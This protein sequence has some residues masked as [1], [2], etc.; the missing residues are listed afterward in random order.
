MGSYPSAQARAPS[1]EGD[2]AQ[3]KAP[4]TSP[5]RPTDAV[6]CGGAPERDV[7][8]LDLKELRHDE[9]AA[10]L[11]LQPFGE[12]VD[13]DALCAAARRPGGDPASLD[14]RR[15]APPQRRSTLLREARADA[16]NLSRDESRIV[17]SR[18]RRRRRSMLGEAHADAANL[19]RGE[20]PRPQVSA[21][22]PT[23]AELE[24]LDCAGLRDRLGV[25]PLGWR[26]AVLR[27]VAA[28]ADA[29]SKR[30]D[31]AVSSSL[32]TFRW[33]FQAYRASV[34][35]GRAPPVTPESDDASLLTWPPRRR[36]APADVAAAPAPAPASD[37]KDRRATEGAGA[38]AAPA[39]ASDG[40][41]KGSA[42]ANRERSPLL[43]DASMKQ[44]RRL[45]Y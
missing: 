1:P 15:G 35:N 30:R 20:R 6:R 36:S 12:S 5:S 19:S 45:F 37:R 25:A 27:R 34:Q 9:V 17:A 8:S 33:N 38:V 40:A 26:K 44:K 23:G 4:K 7:T 43:E 10:W 41:R 29:L 11:R 16:A 32:T 2:G 3:P 39:P 14:A 24:A 42:P 31:D 22:R 13:V 21:K 28:H 18:G